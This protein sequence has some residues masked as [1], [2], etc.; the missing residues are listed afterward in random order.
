M[1]YISQMLMMSANGIASS[2]WDGVAD[3]YLAA[4]HRDSPYLSIYGRV[5]STFNRLFDPTEL[6]TGLGN[7]VSFSTDGIHLV[8]ALS[9][10]PYLTIYKRSNNTFTKLP[11]PSYLPDRDR[12]SLAFSSN[13]VYLAVGG[14]YSPYIDVYIRNQDTDTF[15][16]FY[17]SN[18]DSSTTY[19]LSFSPDGVYLAAAQSDLRG[20]NLR[21]Y[22]RGTFGF[23]KLPEEAIDFQPPDR[24]RSVAFSPD[25]IYLVLGHE[26]D[27][28]APTNR[29][30][31]IYKRN[32]DIF[33]KLDDPLEVPTDESYGAA[34]SPDGTLLVVGNGGT[35][36][37]YERNNDTFTKLPDLPG[38]SS[39]GLVND[40]SFSADGTYLAFGRTG[41]PYLVIYERN[42]TTF[43]KLN[44]PANIPQSPIYGISFYL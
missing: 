18:F 1:D 13:G 5:G 34:F 12:Y 24:G 2:G 26:D 9:S 19:D 39:S 10:S 14:L 42:G 23:A 30:L 35:P 6:P 28:F 29:F 27:V 15:T 40:I 4:V 22:K 11:D 31:T 33:N 41:S 32:G 7:D 43:N 17:S 8:L 38:W 44:T 37:V 20:E 3:G 36:Y 21:V 16:L 25:G